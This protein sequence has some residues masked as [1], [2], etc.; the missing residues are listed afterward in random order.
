MNTADGFWA[1]VNR[2][3]PNECWP[4]TG[5]KDP[6][7]YGSLEF[8]GRKDRAH[9]ISYALTHGSIPPGLVI[10]HVCHN[11]TCVN[12]AH[13]QAVTQKQNTENRGPCKVSRSGI[14]GVSWHRPARKW[15]VWVTHDGQKHYGGV[16]ADL[17][18]AE[19]TAIAI[20]SQL[21]TNNLADRSSAA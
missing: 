18:E 8:R 9:R 16:F 17:H 4:W 10:D 21:F 20:R 2:R 11:L 1:R 6:R 19:K 3:G 12:P 15:I 13:L 7:G 5:G 14:R